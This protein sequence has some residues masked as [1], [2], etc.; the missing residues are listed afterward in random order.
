MVKTLKLVNYMIFFLSIFLVVKN[1]DGD[2]VVFQYVFDGC[3]IDADCP[4][5][6]LQLLKWMCIN[7]ECEF[8]H[9][10]PRYV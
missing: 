8:N 1:V 2:D 3:R 7:N 10:R 9:V 6:G 4:I 5:S